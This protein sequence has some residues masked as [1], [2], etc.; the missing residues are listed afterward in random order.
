MGERAM[1]EEYLKRIL[2]LERA[3]EKCYYETFDLIGKVALYHEKKYLEL[4]DLFK[5]ERYP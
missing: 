4:H 5:K 2:D 1:N 3:H